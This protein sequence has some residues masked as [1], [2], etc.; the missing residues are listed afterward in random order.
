MMYLYVLIIHDAIIINNRF[1]RAQLVMEKSNTD[2]EII[3]RNLSLIKLM[4]YEN[5]SSYPSIMVITIVAIL[6]RN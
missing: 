3:S 2:D 4:P 1:R 5:S 6:Q